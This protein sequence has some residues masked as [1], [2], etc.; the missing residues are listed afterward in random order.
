MFF[1]PRIQARATWRN[2]SDAGRDI[3]ERELAAR[4]LRGE[5]FVAAELGEMA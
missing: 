3:P 1:P 4:Y 2:A 5:F